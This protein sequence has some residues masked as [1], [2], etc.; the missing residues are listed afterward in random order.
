M[1]ESFFHA[2]GIYRYGADGDVFV[3]VYV[4]RAPDGFAH[5]DDTGEAAFGWRR[6]TA[7]DGAPAPLGA[8]TTADFSSWQEIDDA[9]LAD[10]LGDTPVP[11]RPARA[12]MPRRQRPC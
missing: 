3:V 12:A 4:G 6:S 8:Y 10:A 2:G 7:P 1:G 9:E 11:D 5:P